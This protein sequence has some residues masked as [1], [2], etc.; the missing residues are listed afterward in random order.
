MLPSEV[1]KLI[2][3]AGDITI[4]EVEKGAI[5]RYVDAIGD[6]N[7][8]YWDDEYA[9]VDVKPVTKYRIPCYMLCLHN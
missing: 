4:M 7:P 5:K 2:G 8:I 6:F 9:D 3:N 1:I